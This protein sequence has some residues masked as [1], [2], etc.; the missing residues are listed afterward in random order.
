[1]VTNQVVIK[2][3]DYKII[4]KPN[5]AGKITVKKYQLLIRFYTK[6]QMK[7]TYPNNN[8][9]VVG[10]IGN[11][12]GVQCGTAEN[13]DGQ[14]LPMYK[15]WSH[16]RFTERIVGYTAIDDHTYLAVVKNIFLRRILLL[17]LIIALIGTG[18][19][20]ICTHFN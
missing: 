18:T 13:L 19:I 7:T 16:D 6:K 3:M 11:I 8:F 17:V 4:N 10:E 14:P 5:Y 1:M 12:S 20:I 2:R 9:R 15:E